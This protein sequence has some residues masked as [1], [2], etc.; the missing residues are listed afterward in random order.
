MY[1]VRPGVCLGCGRPLP[2]SHPAPNPSRLYHD[3]ACQDL[4]RRNLASFFER[5]PE[6]PGWGKSPVARP[7][8]GNRLRVVKASNGRL[9]VR[10]EKGPAK[11]AVREHHATDTLP[12]SYY[13]ASGA[14]LEDAAAYLRESYPEAEV[15]V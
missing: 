11:K 9:A 6:L 4:H 3:E 2:R 5:N 7:G 10:F 13:L 8:P 14:G 15:V 12:M 1:K